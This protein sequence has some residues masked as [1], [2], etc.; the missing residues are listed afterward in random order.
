MFRI[1]KLY[2][3]NCGHP[4]AFYRDIFYD[5]TSSNGPVH[6]LTVQPNG[7]GKT[8]IISFL[9]SL[10]RPSLDEFIQTK[11]DLSKRYS[12]YFNRRP[13]TLLCELE[14]GSKNLFIGQYVCLGEGDRITR[15]FFSMEVAAD[16]AE[17]FFAIPN[18]YGN[19]KISDLSDCRRWLEEHNATLKS[20]FFYD[21][22]QRK[23]MDH[24]T[25]KGI[26]LN[27]IYAMMQCCHQEGGSADEFD[28][29]NEADFLKYYFSLVLDKEDVDLCRRVVTQI[30]EDYK[31]LPL[32]KEHA[33]IIN[34]LMENFKP[35]YEEAKTFSEISKHFIGIR[36][37]AHELNQ[38]IKR[39]LSILSQNIEEFKADEKKLKKQLGECNS[40]LQNAHIEEENLTR[41]HIEI[42]I[43]SAIDK[44][45]ETKDKCKVIFWEEVSY[46]RY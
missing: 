28:F 33:T 26:D 18:V 20:R 21:D 41:R 8:T 42:R 10:F 39:K 24:L 15:Y 6:T 31:E 17:A 16:A 43:S 36:H 37:D 44:I 25:S 27:L 40:S 11:T 3:D 14:M 34:Q 7:S 9:A 45:K 23:W 30:V 1:N 12:D 38:A 13:A 29:K 46:K 22:H 32:A 4:N 2:F 35:F 19:K 5:F